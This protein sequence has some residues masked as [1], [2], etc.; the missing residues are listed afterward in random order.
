MIRGYSSLDDPRTPSD[1]RLKYMGPFVRTFWDPKSVQNRTLV[2]ESALL[3][4]SYK[5]SLEE[6]GKMHRA[7]VQILAGTDTPAP[8]CFPGFS[9]HDELHL[10]VQAGL[11]PMEALQTATRNP[12]RYLD[13]LPELG[14]VEK[15]K[16]AD[17]V[18]LDAN[19]LEEI[20]NT[21]RIAAVIVRGELLNNAALHKLL[22][23]SKF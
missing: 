16:I 12:A 11:T 7:G 23:I 3:K 10:L 8:N 9:V 2:E 13:R 14:T 6:V 18:L 15:G 17:L 20:R 19:P 5:R 4:R 1:P 21:Q 22:G